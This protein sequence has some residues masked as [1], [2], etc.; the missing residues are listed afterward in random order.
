MRTQ[1]SWIISYQTHRDLGSVPYDTYDVR[2]QL[3]DAHRYLEEQKRI[4]TP[5]RALTEEMLRKSSM[6]Q[7]LE[8]SI[9][10]RLVPPSSTS[11]QLKYMRYLKV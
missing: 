5:G 4:A 8:P 1:A 6:M 11:T 7:E 9:G 10:R 2:R 3:Q